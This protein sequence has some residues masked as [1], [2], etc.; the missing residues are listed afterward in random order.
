MQL[1]FRLF[2]VEL[3]AAPDSCPKRNEC[4][5]W[6]LYEFISFVREICS[7]HERLKGTKGHKMAGF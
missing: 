3:F 5:L 6:T 1:D 7:F 2:F 4:G